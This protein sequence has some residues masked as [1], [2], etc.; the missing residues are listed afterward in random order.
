MEDGHLLL[1]KD[2][3]EWDSPQDLNDVM[4]HHQGNGWWVGTV[5]EFGALSEAPVIGDDVLMAD[6]STSVNYGRLWVN[7]GRLWA[8]LDY[9]VV[10]PVAVLRKDGEVIF[11]L[12]KT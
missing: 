6:D 4:E 7:H 10:D 5:D 8:F 3:E 2:N 1:V 11:T 9:Q 12:V